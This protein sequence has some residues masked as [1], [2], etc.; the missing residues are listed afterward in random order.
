MEKVALAIVGLTQSLGYLGI[1]FLM[2]LESSFFPFPSEVV[3]PPAG[4]LAATGKMNIFMVIFCGI[5]GSVMG[6]LVNY[7]LAVRFGRIFLFKY[8]NYFFMGADKLLKMEKFF[9]S[10]GEITTFVGRLIPGVRQYISFP[11]G[12]ARMNVARFVGY[13]AA[14]AGIWVVILAYV[15]FYVG[16]NMEMV[17]EKLATITMIILPLL[18]LLVLFYIIVYKKYV[19]R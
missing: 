8:G 18:L 5:F 9:F 1:I 14:G 13:T 16:K 4:F 2:A 11:A 15:G 12:L 6:A 17:K 3:V 19:K 7:Y 10:H